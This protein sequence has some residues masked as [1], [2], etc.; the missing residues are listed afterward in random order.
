VYWR[1]DK[2]SAYERMTPADIEQLGRE[3]D[4]HRRRAFFP[5]FSRRGLR[6]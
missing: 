1:R 3:F 5:D 6:T 2:G 4:A